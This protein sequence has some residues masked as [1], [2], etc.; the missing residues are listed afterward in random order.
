M[1]LFTNRKIENLK[2]N[3]NSVVMPE[4]VRE[5]LPELVSKF[6][7]EYKPST[8]KQACTN[9]LVE[10]L[11]AMRPKHKDFIIISDYKENE[12]RIVPVE[13]GQMVNIIFNV[14]NYER[15]FLNYNISC[16]LI[17]MMNFSKEF[18]VISKYINEGYY[19]CYVH[20]Y[21]LVFGKIWFIFSAIPFK[22]NVLS[23]SALYSPDLHMYLNKISVYLKALYSKIEATLN[24]VIDGKISVKSKYK[25]IV[26]SS[27]VQTI[28]TLIK[29]LRP[30]L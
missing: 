28:L 20:P 22:K 14:N 3:Y 29:N 10:C 18:N 23:N 27:E 5:C 13:N 16:V 25:V 12:K 9:E 11:N 8:I 21:Y 6:F 19:Q 2:L 7:D 30:K 24:D 15:L 1:T 26:N 4:N 17:D